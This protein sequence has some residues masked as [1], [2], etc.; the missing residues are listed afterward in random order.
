MLAPM[1][2]PWNGGLRFG[3]GHEARGEKDNGPRETL[4]RSR[5]LFARAVALPVRASRAKRGTGR[6]LGVRATAM[7][8]W[9]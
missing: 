3:L 5:P 8:K 6:L 7:V 2:A 9:R 4:A 1:L